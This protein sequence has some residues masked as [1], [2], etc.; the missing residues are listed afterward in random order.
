MKCIIQRNKRNYQACCACGQLLTNAALPVTQNVSGA[1]VTKRWNWPHKKH[2][3]FAKRWLQ[4]RTMWSV[5]CIYMLCNE[6]FV[7]RGSLT[8]LTSQESSSSGSSKLVLQTCHKTFYFSNINFRKPHTVLTRKEKT[9]QKNSPNDGNSAV[10]RPH[11]TRTRHESCDE[12]KQ[13]WRKKL[14]CLRRVIIVVIGN[15]K[16]KVGYHIKKQKTF[17]LWNTCELGVHLEGLKCTA[18]GRQERGSA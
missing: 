11:V 6:A 5:C 7:S 3:I 2:A 12:V 15:A 13:K 18:R 17:T 4:C 8:A 10:W 16:K 9:K 14:F 1:G